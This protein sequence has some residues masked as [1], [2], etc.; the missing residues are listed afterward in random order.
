MPRIDTDADAYAVK[1]LNMFFPAN[2]T[3]WPGTNADGDLT[4][5]CVTLVKWFM[6]E[7][8]NVPNPFTARG[9]ARYVG[10]NLVAQGHAVEVPYDQR[11][12]GDIIC[13]E[14]GTYGHIYVQL[15]GGRR[16]EENANV[17]G[18]ARRVLRD[19]TV[20]YASRIGTD[21]EAWLAGKNP[22]C[23]RLKTYT[24]QGSDEPMISNVDN[25]FA[26]WSKLY[27]QIRN[28]EVPPTRQQFID[29]AVGRSWLTAMEILSDNPSADEAIENRKVGRQA[30]ADNWPG[31][32]YGLQDALA[33][34]QAAFNQAQADLITARRQIEDLGTRPTQQQLD[35]LTAQ[36]KAAEADATE[37]Q[38]ELL[39]AN[40]A[41]EKAKAG[42]IADEQRANNFM[43]ALAEILKKFWPFK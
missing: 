3:P 23:Y 36:L 13:L 12:R 31:Q 34:A 39:A 32:I 43:Q 4:G 10:Q 28:T 17:G 35:D 15:S 14:Y 42:Q 40:D 11:R 6:A 7:M 8:S 18:A 9:D 30:R 29:A 16:F 27:I 38:K 5:Q 26:R 22:H 33:K 21:A 41:L 25:E 19:G 2:S 24:E 1:R 37:K 20:V